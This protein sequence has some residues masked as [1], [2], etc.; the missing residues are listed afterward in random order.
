MLKF[1]LIC[2][3]FIYVTYKVSNFLLK[4]FF[5]LQQARRMQAEF[6]RKNGFGPK[7]RREQQHKH[8]SSSRTAEGSIHV[9]YV[10]EKEDRATRTTQ[11]FKGGD[12]VDYEEVK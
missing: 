11:D 3:I 7:H 6:A 10:P 5:P 4:L 1:I 8:R 12:Y 2:I 9:D